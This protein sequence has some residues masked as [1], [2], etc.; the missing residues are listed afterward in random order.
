M[1]LVQMVRKCRAVA[2]YLFEDSLFRIEVVFLL[3]ECYPY[4]LQ[5]HYLSAGIRFVLPGQNPQQRC[6]AGPVRRNQRHLVPFIYVEA[7]M[8]EQHLGSVRLRYVFYLQVTCH[9]QSFFVLN[10]ASGIIHLLWSPLISMCRGRDPA[11]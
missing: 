3:Q 9:F 8:V 6:L 5:E 1:F 11:A 2:H 10:R 7:Y 4:V